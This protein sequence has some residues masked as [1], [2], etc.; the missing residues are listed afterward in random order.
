[1][2]VINHPVTCLMYLIKPC[3][4]SKEI[5]PSERRA[6]SQG[7]SNQGSSVHTRYLLCMNIRMAINSR[8]LNEGITREKTEVRWAAFGKSCKSY[9]RLKLQLRNA[10]LSASKCLLVGVMLVIDTVTKITPTPRLSK[11]R[12]VNHIESRERCSQDTLLL[13]QAKSLFG[14]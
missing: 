14:F 13:R 1:M 10:G 8:G 9:E 2:F 11:V 4:K 7:D 5:V 6:I 3:M 12:Y